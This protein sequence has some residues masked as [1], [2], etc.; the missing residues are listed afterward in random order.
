MLIDHET[1]IKLANW[2]FSL[3]QEANLGMGQ[4][5]RAAVL[6]RIQQCCQAFAATGNLGEAVDRPQA[7]AWIDI[8]AAASVK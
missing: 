5:H 4:S 6:A 1:C 3:A 8:E 7:I 2:A